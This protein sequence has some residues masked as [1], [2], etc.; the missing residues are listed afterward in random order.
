[1]S[2]E[3][4]TMP[5]TTSPGLDHFVFEEHVPSL[6]RAMQHVHGK[7]MMAQARL[8]VGKTQFCHNV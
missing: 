8:A 6:A 3:Q 2:E 4:G 1:M 7:I 5:K